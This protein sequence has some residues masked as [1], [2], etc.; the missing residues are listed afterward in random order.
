[1]NL[2]RFIFVRL[3]RVGLYRKSV[4]IQGSTSLANI[5]FFDIAPSYPAEIKHM[6]PQPAHFS[7]IAVEPGTPPPPLGAD[8]RAVL[9]EAE[10]G[11]SEIDK[12]IAMGVV[13][14]PPIPAFSK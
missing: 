5:G 2:L 7:G 6:L 11:A 10:L 4:T 14:A 1:M 9:D 12:L 13:T 3:L 8:S